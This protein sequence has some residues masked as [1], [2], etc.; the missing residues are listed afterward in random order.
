MARMKGLTSLVEALTIASIVKTNHW[1]NPYCI[2]G[3]IVGEEPHR[4]AVVA[5][6]DGSPQNNTNM[7]SRKWRVPSAKKVRTMSEK[8]QM[9]LKII[10]M[11]LLLGETPAG[12]A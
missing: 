5:P 3:R 8:M 2:S 1:G 9:R 10:V 6:V 4:D 11:R 12:E 7:R